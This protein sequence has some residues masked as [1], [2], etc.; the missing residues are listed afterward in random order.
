MS[1]NGFKGNHKLIDGSAVAID[2]VKACLASTRVC[3]CAHTNIGLDV[4]SGESCQCLSIN[5]YVNV[6]GGIKKQH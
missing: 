4:C 2:S 1:L 3:G 5:S 6:S